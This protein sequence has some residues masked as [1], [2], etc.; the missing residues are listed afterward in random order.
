MAYKKIIGRVFSKLLF[1]ASLRQ[2]TNKARCL[3]SANKG[4][5][6]ITN[7]EINQNAGFKSRLLNRR[8]YVLFLLLCGC[9]SCPLAHEK[10]FSSPTSIISP[11]HVAQR[12]VKGNKRYVANQDFSIRRQE[13]ATTQNPMAVVLSCA[14]SRVVPELLFNQGLGDLFVV[15]LA[16]NFLTPEG[17]A[18]I[19][20]ALKELK[21][22]LLIVLGHSS[23]GAVKAAV[24]TR[25]PLS[26]Y[27]S[28]LMRPI[29]PAVERA[30]QILLKSGKE[31]TKTQLLEQAIIE[32]VRNTVKYLETEKRIINLQNVN[33]MGAVYN[34]S[35]GVVHF[36]E[37]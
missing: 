35:T 20:Y 23:C 2:V 19:Q 4:P 6:R 25:A 8:N 10:Q 26:G 27:L 24:E 1:C 17:L 34:M 15:R 29:M 5:N 3:L 36:L 16:G 30:K 13:T 18:S 7:E 37:P 21:A 28:P 12:L 14:D 22:P 11:V 32:N 31:G 33:I 9:L